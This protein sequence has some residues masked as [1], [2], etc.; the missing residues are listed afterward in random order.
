MFRDVIG[1]KDT[2]V[3]IGILYKLVPFYIAYA[4][5]VVFQGV[6]T[7]IGRTEFILAEAAVVNIVYYGILYGLFLAGFFEATLDFVILLFG[8]GM[9]V[10]L[11]L[12]VGFYLYSRRLIPEEYRTDASIS[13]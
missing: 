10:S 2:A 7:S 4:L 9:V 11:V 3:I 13:G 12:D 5:C 8:F 6:M 1:A